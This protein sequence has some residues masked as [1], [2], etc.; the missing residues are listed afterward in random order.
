MI[1][2][3]LWLKTK[4]EHNKLLYKEYGSKPGTF[5]YTGVL[6]LQKYKGLGVSIYFGVNELTKGMISL[7]VLETKLQ[8][9]FLSLTDYI[10]SNKKLVKKMLS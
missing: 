2:K 6:P 9:A 1:N 10:C 7:D 5:V 8:S 4:K 3:K